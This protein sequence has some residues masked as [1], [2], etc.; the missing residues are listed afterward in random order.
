MKLLFLSNKNID[1]NKSSIFFTA[2]TGGHGTH[3]AGSVAGKVVG[4]IPIDRQFSKGKS[5]DNYNG[6]AYEAK[7]AFF[8]IGLPRNPALQVPSNLETTMLNYAYDAGARIHTNSW[9]G[10]SNSYSSN[11]KDMDS[12]MFKRQD[13][14]ILVAAGNSG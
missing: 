1:S 9:G 4:S 6:N 14:L 12:F 7:V 5:Y 8:D 2:N 13:F 3:V 11:S 10:N